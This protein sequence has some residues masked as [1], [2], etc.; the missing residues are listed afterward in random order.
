MAKFD[1]DPA[2]SVPVGADDKPLDFDPA[3]SVPVSGIPRR[4][5]G[6]T[7]ISAAKGVIGVG[8]SVIGA[9]DLLSGGHAGKALQDLGV[10]P[11]KAKAILD[12]QYTPEQQIAN[13]KLAEAKGF[14]PTIGAALSNPS[15]IIQSAVESAPSMFG[16][17]A[18]GRGVMK[19]APKV[20]AVTAGAIGEGAVS[21]A[22]NTEQIRQDTA[23]GLLTGEQAA[24]GA[25]SGALTGAISLGAGKVAKRLGIT[26]VDTMLA[27]G[28]ARGQGKGLARRVGEGFLSE[29]LLEEL[30]QSAQEQVAQNLA[31]G[32]PWD[33]G[34]SEAAAMGAL[35]GGL[36][37]GGAN[38]IQGRDAP[39]V[40]P[41][42]EQVIAGL[43]PAPGT[44]PIQADD[45][46]YQT[47]EGVAAAL[48]AERNATELRAARDA[49][50]AR[51]AGFTPEAA[52]VG[53]PSPPIDAPLMLPAPGQTSTPDVIAPTGSD[54]PSPIIQ[55]NGAQVAADNAAAIYAAREQKTV[56]LALFARQGALSSA[57]AA[58]IRPESQIAP[59]AS[60]VSAQSPLAAAAPQATLQ[61]T[62]QA[63]P[64]PTPQGTPQAA[65]PPAGVSPPL[66]SM[67]VAQ[68]KAQEITARTGQTYEAVP[69]PTVP[70]A[71][72]VQPLS[73]TSQRAPVGDNTVS[74]AAP[75]PQVADAKPGSKEYEQALKDY[76]ASL[77]KADRAIKYDG[78]VYPATGDE[79][80]VDA[81]KRAVE[82]VGGVDNFDPAKM[83][84][85]IVTPDGRFLSHNEHDSGKSGLY[86][87]NTDGISRSAAERGMAAAKAARQD[88]AK[89][90]A[91]IDA[92]AAAAATSPTNDL[93]HPTSGQSLAGNYKKAHIPPALLHGLAAT[94]ENPHG[95]IRVAA[96]GTWA[97]AT[98]GHYGYLKR[99][100]G[101]D[102]DQ[103][104]VNIGPKPELD[105]A[106]VI[107]QNDPA[108]GKFDEHK[109]MLGYAT[110]EEAEAAYRANYPADW[111]GFGAIT[112]TTPAGVKEWLR[113]GAATK[114]FAQ[115]AQPENAGSQSENTRDV[116]GKPELVFSSDADVAAAGGEA[117]VDE[118]SVP[119]TR[120]WFGN[121]PQY[122]RDIDKVVEMKP[123]QRRAFAA[124]TKRLIELGMPRAALRGI[125]AVIQY[126]KPSAAFYAA[127]E[128][129][130][131][132]A[133]DVLDAA[134]EGQPKAMRQLVGMI[135]H[136]LGHHID[137]TPNRAWFNTDDSPA[138]A[139]DARVNQG[140]PYVTR[141][142]SGSVI[143]E[144]FEAYN[145]DY[146]K[147]L[148]KFLK[149]PLRSWNANPTDGNFG[150]MLKNEVWAQLWRLYFTNPGLMQ[151]HLP[152]SFNLV[153]EVASGIE[154]ARTADDA[155]RAVWRT[156]SREQ[157][158]NGAGRGA[159]DGRGNRS[160]G[161]GAQVREARAGVDAEAAVRRDRGTALEGQPGRGDAG[162]ATAPRTGESAGQAQRL[163]GLPASSPGPFPVAQK[164]AADYMKKAGLPY[165]PPTDFVK[166]DPAYAKRIADAYAAMKHSPN[167]VRVKAAYAALARETIAQW[168]AIEATGLDVTF[169]T[170]DQPYPY[171]IPQ[172][173][174][175]DVRNN[176]H[177]WVFPTNDG[178]GSDASF[179]ASEN[180][181]LADTGIVIKGHKLVVNDV[182]RIVHDYFG[183]IK[184]GVGFRA[185]GEENA[186]RIHASMFSP[187]ARRA[188]TSETR[189][190][191]SWLNWGPHG[192]KNRTAKTEDTIF[193]DQKTGL[194]PQEFVDSDVAVD[195]EFPLADPEYRSNIREVDAAPKKTIKAYKLFR[196]K[197]SA[198][199]ELFPLFIGSNKPTPVGAWIAAENIPTKG[200]AQRP[201]WHAGILPTAPHLRTKAGKIAP[202]RVWA[203]VEIPADKDWQAEA[204]KSSTRDI[205]D[206]LP[207]GG[208]YRFATSK[209]Q[210]GAWIIGGSIKI[211][212]VLSDAE[213]ASILR[214]AGENEA[215]EAEQSGERRS[216]VSEVR[217]DG[218]DTVSPRNP[219]AK[220]ATENALDDQLQIGLAALRADPEA[221]E[222]NIRIASRYPN[223]ARSP[224]RNPEKRAERMV[225]HMVDNLVWLH[226]H[227][228]DAIRKR[229][230]MWYDGA[231]AIAGKWASEYGVSRRA[232]AGMM[233][234]LSPQK[235]WFMNVSLAQRVLDIVTKQK[236]KPWSQEMETTAA[237][238]FGKPDQKVVIDAVRGKS[239]AELSDLFEK[240]TWVR[241]YDEAHNPRDYHVIHPEGDFGEFATNQDGRKSKVAWGST[242]TIAKAISIFEQQ[243]VENIHRQLGNEH[244]VRSF[245]NNIVDPNSKGGHVTIDTHA[246]AAALLRPLS[247]NSREVLHNFGGGIKGEGGPMNSSIVG[248]SG[249]YGLYAE[250]YR[251][252]AEARGILPRQMQSITWEAVRGLFTS[253]FKSQQKNVDAVNAVWDDFSK[254]KGTINDVRKEIL[255]LAGGVTE[256]EWVSAP[257]MDEKQGRSVD[258]GAV[259]VAGVARWG[260]G[261][262]VGRGR[263]VSAAAVSQAGS[264][265]ARRDGVHEI[266][267]L[268]GQPF[269]RRP[270]IAGQVRVRGL[271]IPARGRFSLSAEAKAAATK[272]GIPTQDLFEVPGNAGAEAF[273]SAIEASKVG[274]KFASSVYV[275]SA[276]D[277]RSMRLFL[278]EDGKS[279][280][281]LKGDD[282]VS[283]FNNGGEKGIAHSMMLLAAQ[284]GGRRLDA[285]DTVLPHIYA[286]H[287]FEP[288]ARMKWNE[289]YAPD[290]WNKKLYSSYNGGEPDV[291][292]MA[293]TGTF[294]PYD[295]SAGE[296][297]SDPDAASSKQAEML[298]SRRN[299][300]EVDASPEPLWTS[301][302]A[303]AISEKAPFAKDGSIQV[304]QLKMWL[305][306]KSKDGT[307][308][309]EEVKWSGV[310]EWLEALIESDVKKLSREEVS[311]FI[312][313]NGVKIEE[314]MLG[315]MTNEEERAA[316]SARD[317]SRMPKFERDDL[318]LPGGENYREL[319]LTLPAPQTAMEASQAYTD[320]MEAKYG[321]DYS[322][323]DL[324]PEERAEDLEH[325][326]RV[327]NER[328][329]VVQ[330]FASGH[331]EQPNILAHIRFNERAD[332]EGKRVLF[333]EEIQSDWAQL[334][335]KRGFDR[336]RDVDPDDPHVAP[337]VGGVVPSAP[338][339]GKTEAWVA[340]AL[341][342]MIRYAADNGFERVAWTTG[343]QQADRYD[344]SKHVDS[345]SYRKNN[346]GTV[347]VVARDFDGHTALWRSD[348]ATEGEIEET[349]GKDIAK[350]I[351]DGP[352]KGT[353]R[354][355]DLKVGGEGMTAFYDRIVPNVANDLL[356][357]MGGGRVGVVN[358]ATGK[359]G[360]DLLGSMGNSN[361]T[362]QVE[363]IGVGGTFVLKDPVTGMYLADF[364]PMTWASR[365][366][367]GELF[368]SRA[369]AL[370]TADAVK[371]DPLP[372]SQPGFD[373]TPE[374]LPKA[375]RS[376][377]MFVDGN[378]REVSA[379]SVRST[380]TNGIADA[381]RS[382]RAFNLWHRTVGTPYHKAQINPAF[383]KVYDGVQRYMN[384][385]AYMAMEA[386]NLAPDLLPQLEGLSDIVKAGVSGKD[387]KAVSGAVFEGTL[388]K[389]VY[390]TAELR[391]RGMSDE[392]INLYQQARAAIDKSLRDTFATEAIKQAR[393]VLPPASIA[394]ARRSMNAWDIV[395]ELSNLPNRTEV[396][397]QV[398]DQLRQGAARIE[399]LVREGYAP[400]MRFGQY[401]V[402]GTLNGERTFTMHETQFA[403]NRFARALEAAGGTV[404]SN[405][406]MSQEAW[407]LFQGT[408]PDTLEIFAE[409][410]GVSNDQAMQKFIKLTANNRSVLK[411][412]L[413][414]KE[415]AG[416]SDDVQRTVAQFVTSNS[417]AASRNLHFGDILRDTSA[418]DPQTDGGDV[419]DEAVK[420]AQ[421]I[422]NPQE[423]AGALRGLL[424]VQFLGGSIASAATNATQPV[425][426]TF[427]YLSQ[428][429]GALK[430]AGAL[431]GASKI[432]AGGAAADPALAAALKRGTEEGIVAPH[433]VAGLYAEAIRSPGS[434]LAV[435]KA[436]KVWGSLFSLAE[437]FNRRLTFVA[438]WRM[439]QGGGL[440]D[441]NA[442]RAARGLDTFADAYDFAASTIAE[443]QGVYNRGNRPNWARGAVGATLFTF[444][445]Y[446]VSYVEFLKRLPKKERI[447][448]L[449]VL[450]MAAGLQG[451]PGADDAEDVIDTIAE[452][453][454]YSFNSKQ[455]LREWAANV[456]GDTAGGMLT[457]GFSSLPGVPLD[458][459][460][461]LGVGNLIPGTGILKRSTDDR[462]RDVL[463]WF[464]PAGSQLRSTADAFRAAQEGRPGE[465]AKSLFPLAMQNAMKGYDM[466][467]SGFYKD[468]KGRRV[469]DVD[470][471]DAAIKAIGFQPKR[472]ASE[473]RKVQDAQQTISLQR[474]VEDEI[475]GKWARGIID[476]DPLAV[477]AAREQLIRWN[478]TNPGVRIII[479]PA[480]IQRR[481][482]DAMRTRQQR[483]IK[484]APPEI[485]AMIRQEIRDERG[486]VTP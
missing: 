131:G 255:R 208:H 455:A 119:E 222:H 441:I 256:P 476:R 41:P 140:V 40:K 54:L 209:M 201:G 470:G 337:D 217:A 368:G 145:N 134:A 386:A 383:R 444:K 428:F 364:G 422:Q 166:V 427:P 317:G 249:L 379:G 181:L 72:A 271:T 267:R 331:Y 137:L 69:H 369:T 399:D 436:L 207:E 133:T 340:L 127:E 308:K 221:F 102:G 439:A 446:S 473:S 472:V 243:S 484:T 86:R 464:G 233:A 185:N 302:L 341:K 215:A 2:R 116:S 202:G 112:A 280:F 474:D 451:L 177:M 88:P 118:D 111:K 128:N 50:E 35:V 96:D 180:P 304:G 387:I 61:A 87:D 103:V 49:E 75:A 84:S 65:T 195:A 34:V 26:D 392:Q 261:P 165:N 359:T 297:V 481:V 121:A 150:N 188:M 412:L 82:D 157:P 426:M 160:A 122:I 349:L 300:S 204:D 73:A 182:F 78:K 192:E 93:A 220:K 415:I 311:D 232:A 197:A 485:R 465:I 375:R 396:Q 159:V 453:L 30:P 179:D 14:L 372:E 218:D 225:Q 4:V 448:A 250:A 92:I 212:R 191:N 164:A 237:R 323:S 420:L 33:E 265:A 24:L 434:T 205:R 456:L 320:R 68:A 260:A 462:S 108:T 373:I 418:I 8:E 290:G 431:A 245:Y 385:A 318:K 469:I 303:T 32:K 154:Q 135:A 172:E 17:G 400:L 338:F 336:A 478:Q 94:I 129:V 200:F 346:D 380:V 130:I 189:G 433:E 307:V 90:A 479:T 322:Q 97:S 301:G 10:D 120:G 409:A 295:Q 324:T 141:A 60:A 344:L 275:Y 371:M 64:Q 170:K 477:R 83:E 263:D 16:G 288:A 342:R 53:P 18:I 482:Q 299:I 57:A 142:A 357:K 402:E 46:Q 74:G 294:N 326:R 419:K 25:T 293:R 125:R 457:H 285:F 20:G 330:R 168:K 19:L 252:A 95:S 171:T 11:K 325:G 110:A 374:M 210:G 12:E 99:T 283:V 173:V 259:P 339:V 408:S 417:R 286:I 289:E 406:P 37:G 393:G 395:T 475:A 62:P 435:R 126:D 143:K 351:V 253:G 15:T 273:R 421:Y 376:N 463:E 366:E 411:R 332:A 382:T 390:S 241:I 398:Y 468:M 193:A 152:E 328:G 234:V 21:G 391:A 381:L 404:A 254:G 1:F 269:N 483:F 471:Y 450:V 296:V 81:V 258:A 321:P 203:E 43:L 458:V 461:R 194:L 56:E 104:D 334:G 443:T 355:V 176:N 309:G 79:T 59:A 247:G 272:A 198:P 28:P 236:D 124:A 224:L 354:G 329:K 235:D 169:A 7:A 148:T 146:D 270:G 343:E 361:R 363:E 423:E 440:A 216:N 277:Y 240:A 345:I 138:F 76:I 132:V 175:D 315:G 206:R 257:R 186:W 335:R 226:D 22:Q 167:D 239:L 123:H 231:H 115:R 313:Q 246:V 370:S 292:Y 147:E 274:N 452:S 39:A 278:T 454:G 67:P 223:F 45:R 38:V 449:A 358:L 316:A 447:L 13:R 211:N 151:K 405:K 388:N 161:G 77:P 6:D 378:I 3:N 158:D 460:A 248:T 66:A 268:P 251:R 347:A 155:R 29:G 360:A 312:E 459:Q 23:D 52:Q 109:V 144:V 89:T 91:A 445:Q 242:P 55:Q 327:F 397:Q 230:Q 437:G 71:F 5:I 276:D 107:D 389:V 438:A 306:A 333:I 291:V 377:L 47:A 174:F 413:Q 282:I 425:L 430:A 367:D 139:L 262:D 153:K 48:E 105:T 31:L 184:E 416:F 424:F 199:G 63:T 106:F 113:E 362:L 365:P 114:P 44:I 394:A 356:K 298:S 183:H 149:Y 442:K 196:T 432:A 228:S 466:A 348:A 162:L 100:S 136:E 238:I 85:G 353:L 403:A 51:K 156:L 310:G 9:A 384:D 80:H 281:A 319:L 480:Q 27:G 213:V 70:N 190:Q 350:K 244:K 264:D 266:R 279:G 187:L 36:I 117:Q 352:V 58:G 414:R 42:P 163:T 429:G 467:S 101:A 401:A 178:F 284:E 214:A 227:V 219:T 287:G 229:S 98:N 407:K 314:V 486:I 410:M 305:A